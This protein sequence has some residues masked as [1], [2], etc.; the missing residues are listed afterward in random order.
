MPNTK[1]IQNLKSKI[2]NKS[3]ITNYKLPIT[4]KSNIQ[5]PISNL[6]FIIIIAAI[7][8]IIAGLLLNDYAEIVFR[9]PLLIAAM[10]SVGALLLFYSDKVGA[11]KTGMGNI[12]LKDGVI[13]GLAQA[14]A[15]IPGMSR[16]GI[17]IAAA[18]LIGLNRTSAAR[19]S[20]LLSAPIILGAGVKE[21]PNLEESGIDINII[22]G[23]G[24]AALSGFAAI[25]YMLKYLERRS[26]NIFVVYRIILAAA[27][28]Y[29]IGI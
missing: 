7:P 6:L 13:I 20:F 21:F 23:A 24:A 27:I 11:K 10:L 2:T 4:D 12:T 16:S 5:Y 15:I 17:T 18:L 22:I 29:F 1:Q 25:K 9:N 28:I 8:G 19:F 26:Y 3:Q 14:L